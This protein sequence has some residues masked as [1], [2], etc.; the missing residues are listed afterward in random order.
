[1]FS[2]FLFIAVSAILFSLF[3]AA[4]VVSLVWILVSLMLIIGVHKVN[5]C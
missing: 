1:M 5:M 3:G 4:L 2:L